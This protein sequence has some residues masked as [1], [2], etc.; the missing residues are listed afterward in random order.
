MN[1]FRDVTAP[2][3]TTGTKVWTQA[4]IVVDRRPLIGRSICCW[5]SS[6]GPEFDPVLVGS[7]ERAAG[8][9]ALGRARAV[10]WST[11]SPAPWQ[12]EWLS[13]EIACTLAQRQDVPIVLL[14]DAADR[15]IAEEAARQLNLSGYIPTSSNL[16]LAAT[17]L[18]LVLAGGRYL[19][20]K[21]LDADEVV[22]S[23][24]PA[25]TRP[26]CDAR[27]TMRERAVL[28]LLER[29]LPNKLI[30]YRLG[31]SQSTVKAHVHNIIA[32]LNVRNRTE[33]A[34]ARYAGRTVTAGSQGEA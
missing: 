22:P 18:R 24:P 29:G 21:C 10:I 33:A 9:E 15:E 20:G 25:P 5:I 7:I 11:N 27:L 8:R 28:D 23:A 26:T 19:P 34:M 6:L 31:M 16:E 14:A 4:M 32:K 1:A 3:V 12:D 17:A 30:A 13:N 2:P